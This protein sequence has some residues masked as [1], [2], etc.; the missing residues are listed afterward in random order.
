MPVTGKPNEHGDLYATV[1]VQ[2]PRNLTPE[3]R[4]HYEQLQKL[5]QRAKNSAA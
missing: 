2:L 5:E 1:D 3:Q 4:G